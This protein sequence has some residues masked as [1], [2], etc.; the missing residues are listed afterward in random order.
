MARVRCRGLMVGIDL[1]PEVGPSRPYCYTFKDRGM[2]C[3]D[4]HVQTIRLAPPLVITKDQID[5]A[6][7]KLEAVLAKGSSRPSS[8]SGQENVRGAWCSLLIKL[9][10]GDLCLDV[11]QY[12]KPVPRKRIGECSLCLK[13]RMTGSNDW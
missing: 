11:R 1:K 6:I 5:W 2:L 12:T 4:T 8:I 3:K 10:N 13:K 7:E 9:K